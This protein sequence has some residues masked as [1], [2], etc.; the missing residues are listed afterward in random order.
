[1]T[2]K[3]SAGL[4]QVGA[5]MALL[6]ICLLPLGIGALLPLVPVGAGLALLGFLVALGSRP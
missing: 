2:T 5:A 1:M 3:L 6:P 4:M